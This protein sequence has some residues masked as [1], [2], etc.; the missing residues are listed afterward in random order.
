MIF[1]VTSIL[2][3]KNLISVCIDLPWKE[4]NETQARCVFIFPL[5]WG[6]KLFLSRLDLP[7]MKNKILSYSQDFL[8][9]KPNTCLSFNFRKDYYL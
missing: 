8:P 1:L 7:N 4:E 3:M 6:N 5:T 9:R 2:L